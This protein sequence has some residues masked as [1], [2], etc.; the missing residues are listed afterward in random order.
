MDPFDFTVIGGGSAGYAA[1]RTAAA[2][3]MKT[4]VI[5][6]ADELGGLCILRGCMPSKT[7]IESANRALTLRRASEFGLNATVGQPDVPA[8]RARKRHLIEDFASYRQGQ[9]QDG[10]FTLLRA[11]ASFEDAHTVL[12]SLINGEPSFS[13]RSHYFCIASGSV[14]HIPPVPGLDQ[15]P[16]WTSDDILDTDSLP[17]SCIVLGGGA[18]ALEMAHYL[19]ALGTH[20]TLIQRSAQL[21]TGLDPEASQTLLHAYSARG[22]DCFC[23][24]QIHR[25]GQ[26]ATGQKEI[27]FSSPTGDH[28]LVAEQLLVS[29]GRV[30]NTDSLGLANAHLELAGK[31]V[32]TQSTQQTNHPHIFAAGDV[33]SPLDVVH[34]AIQQGEIAARNAHRLHTQSSDP[35]EQMDYRLKL[36]GVFSH[37]QVA[38]V[39][40]SEAE[41]QAQNIPFLVASYPFDDHGK[42]M[43]MGETE[44]FVKMLA[45]AHTGEILGALCV[46]PEAT[47]LIHEVV[48]AMNF[49]A[50]AAQFLAI[51]HYHPT[52][53]EIWTYPAEDLADQIPSS[54]STSAS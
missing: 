49:R 1:A 53:S 28:H 17:S 35:L 48:V 36:F 44:G 16:F 37:P 42:S 15:T 14:A 7:L 27:H 29:L 22:I 38:A 50:T 54:T 6:G 39:G 19:N 9:L 12:V 13:L 20:V 3:G 18:I 46:G 11:R 23:Q 33:S 5:D 32:V 30:P 10:R 41:L 52:L 34:L 45:H 24:T 51:P 2:L 47:E 26:S 8:I 40:S 31:K 25:I 43:T 21:L 4:A